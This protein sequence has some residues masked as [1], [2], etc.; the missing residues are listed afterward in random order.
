M[1]SNIAVSSWSS[2]SPLLPAWPSERTVLP[3]LRK[4][5]DHTASPLPPGI[6]SQSSSPPAHHSSLPHP[7]HGSFFSACKKYSPLTHPERTPAS[8]TFYSGWV[9]P[10]LHFPSTLLSASCNL[11]I[12]DFLL[13]YSLKGTQWPAGCHSQWQW[14]DHHQL[15][16]LQVTSHIVSFCIV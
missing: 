8:S 15:E 12:S 13:W 3:P 4:E 2:L 6:C 5:E 9:F 14:G 1:E 16:G 11:F 10:C 7:L